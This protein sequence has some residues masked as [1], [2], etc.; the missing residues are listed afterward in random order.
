M[1]HKKAVIEAAIQGL[2]EG[3]MDPEKAKLFADL[4]ETMYNAGY[5]EAIRNSKW[6]I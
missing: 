6:K 2:I 4:L 1:D 3:G 5:N